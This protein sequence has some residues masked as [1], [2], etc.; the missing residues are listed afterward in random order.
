MLQPKKFKHS[1]KRTRTQ[2][3]SVQAL[4]QELFLDKKVKR[5]IIYLCDREP[6]P[7]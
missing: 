2:D 4:M 6:G 7:K 3:S 1:S 5:A